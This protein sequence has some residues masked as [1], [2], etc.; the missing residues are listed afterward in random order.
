M[1]RTM[2]SA[3][4]PSAIAMGMSG[5]TR[6]IAGNQRARTTTSSTPSNASG[7]AISAGAKAA[8]RSAAMSRG[9]SG[10]RSLSV[11][12]NALAKGVFVSTY[13]TVEVAFDLAKDA[14]N[15][16]KHGVSLARAVDLAVLA[17]VEDD[18]YDEPRFRLYGTIDGLS[19]CLAGMHRDGIVRVISLRR[20]HSKEMRRY[21]GGQ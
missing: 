18:R 9:A 15:I 10:I 14:I 2:P 13:D 6:G 1:R 12:P 21:V 3:T 4:K 5:A 20:A 17:Y 16:A 7:S 11:N 19:Y 8:W